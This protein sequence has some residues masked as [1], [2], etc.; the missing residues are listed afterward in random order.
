MI[1]IRRVMSM[2]IVS[3]MMIGIVP[4][5]AVQSTASTVQPVAK[6]AA[7]NDILLDA[8][9]YQV[10][11][12]GQTSN[13]A[14]ILP[15]TDQDV[16]YIDVVAQ[17]EIS[18]NMQ[19]S[20]DEVMLNGELS[21]F[22]PAGR[23]IASDDNSGNA[24]NP[25]I[26]PTLA[27]TT[28]R[29]AIW[30]RDHAGT[31]TGSYQLTATVSE[32]LV[33][34][35]EYSTFDLE[36]DP[37]PEAAVSIDLPELEPSPNQPQNASVKHTNQALP[38]TNYPL[39][40]EFARDREILA[41]FSPEAFSIEN[42]SQAFTT[43]ALV[44][45]DASQMLVFEY[46]VGRKTADSITPLHVEVL[47]GANFEA[48]T[49]IS[50]WRIKGQYR[51]GW[52]TGRLNIQ[53][54]RGQTIK[55]RFINDWW[56]IDQPSAQVRDLRLT[57]EIPDWELSN[58]G[59]F[60]I[61]NDHLIGA[62]AVITGAS[63]SLISAPINLNQQVQSLSFRYRT[64]RWQHDGSAPL[65]VEILSGASFARIT[66][67]DQWSLKGRLTDGW[68]EAVLDIQ[69]F[70]G[71]TIKIKI[72]NDWWPHH[73]QVTSIDRFTLNRAVPGWDISNARFVRTNTAAQPSGTP[74][75]VD[76]EQDFMAFDVIE[77]ADFEQTQLV[78]AEPQQPLINLE[79]LQTRAS[80][81]DFAVP[82]AATSIHFEYLLGDL[83]DPSATRRL[84]ITILSGEN[85]EILEF[86][87]GHSFVGSSQAGWQ[88]GRLDLVGYRGKT[89]KL[90]LINDA[91]GRP[92]SQ[93]RA[94]KLVQDVPAWQSQNHQALSIDQNPT[95]G[96]HGYL[97]GHA[98]QL[99]SLDF[100]VP[101]TAQQVRFD[102]QAGFSDNPAA[103]Q[104][105][106]ISILSGR[107]FEIIYPLPANSLLGSTDQ[108]W[109]AL[110]LDLQRFQDQ[111]IKLQF[112]LEAHN[113]AYLR[114]DNVQVGHVLTGWSSSEHTP[115][116]L[117]TSDSN[118]QV[119]RFAG[120]NAH[121]T[122]DAWTVLYDTEALQF[123]YKT[124]HPDAWLRSV[125]EVYVLSGAGFEIVTPIDAGSVYGH[126]NDPN[127]GWH[128]ARLGL[129]QFQGQTI[130]LQFRHQGHGDSTSWLD[131][132]QLI[133]GETRA[134]QAAYHAP[135]HAF[136][137]MSQTWQ[138]V[139]SSGFEV[140]NDSQF[141]RFVYQV[142]N[143]DHG[144]AQHHLAV[145]V[146][147][148]V[149]FTIITRIDQNQLYRSLNDGW[150]IAQL[151]I[152]QFQNQTIK[153]RFV[154]PGWVSAPIARIDKVALLS[155]R[156]SITGP[157]DVPGV[158]YLNV[159][160]AEL[161]GTTTPTTMTINSLVMYDDYMDVAGQVHYSNMTYPFALSG[162]LY[163]SS[164]GT[165]GDIVADLQDTT[166]TFEALYFAL[167]QHPFGPQANPSIVDQN[168]S[169]YLQ[170]HATREATLVDLGL[171]DSLSTLL[172]PL[173]ELSTLT[174]ARYADD[175]WFGK[176]LEPHST[177]EALG[178]PDEKKW[179]WKRTTIGKD[180]SLL[181]RLDFG[182]V[183]AV[184]DGNIGENSGKFGSQLEILGSISNGYV[185]PGQSW[186]A[187]SCD[188][189]DVDNA[190]VTLGSK[191]DPVTVKFVSSG[192]GLTGNEA[193]G[194]Y[195][196]DATFGGDATRFK[197]NQ[198]WFDQFI[199]DLIKSVDMAS[200]LFSI[201][202][203]VGDVAQ[204][205]PE[206]T[207]DMGDKPSLVNTMILNDWDDN[208]NTKIKVL[209]VPFQQSV[210]VKQRDYFM[211]S[212]TVACKK[213]HSNRDMLLRIYWEIPL[214]DN[215]SRKELNVNLYNRSFLV[216]YKSGPCK[217]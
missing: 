103:R 117:E 85:F 76:F 160:L 79:G 4:S 20:A 89:I 73:P 90:Q 10:L 130:K 200:K 107:N 9:D 2:L 171:D 63:A 55:L 99:T 61:H 145:E 93:I 98:M 25:Q 30:V 162:D 144:N 43:E 1:P 184:P 123:N 36:P 170:R 51:L 59:E 37:C 182:V 44:V 122:S 52:Q 139:T 129:A 168:L 153:I 142:G 39:N 41:T 115:F 6:H 66:N 111:K 14:T 50:N 83:D 204:L 97:H 190:G 157:I 206:S 167:R 78:L 208:P 165:P 87:Q 211:V 216:D 53:A 82:P 101:L 69:A 175:Y 46:M 205:F 178:D 191:D 7:L 108:G 131:N 146:L 198:L 32:P 159:P 128:E 65:F 35:T 203:T 17:Q 38:P 124:Q 169:L 58:F 88:Q 48:V 74:L 114:L 189:Y 42:A 18:V 106:A 156:A 179:T 180:C 112:T 13:V 188:I 3:S 100:T 172:S 70:R 49:N 104:R 31:R 132:L 126:G 121:F 34:A 116:V 119:V 164:L 60:A 80:S 210:L 150:K 154:A 67:I 33:A 163:H 166:G 201:P 192:N 147:S 155:P 28:G 125:I 21:L 151:P 24:G 54:F 195:L 186:P 215:V 187:D 194:D 134:K 16:F 94:L 91:Y 209:R 213:Q 26:G 29:Y 22:D 161:A 105:V 113:T 77:N 8:D 174:N 86:P 176:L 57:Q 71:Q 75:N 27:P 19:R 141:L 120:N 177:F 62:Y 45:P 173:F 72:I 133:A 197:G 110:A 207:P 109:Q 40:C 5:K 193:Q 56:W 102:Y 217:N 212:A 183:V 138:H 158:T 136:I 15:K 47:S 118:R 143:K 214:Y 135:D 137:E 23:L 140:A 127:N 148:G 84:L 92:I 95:Q 152:Q 181:Q 12:S 64:G 185:T 149:D 96:N 199:G 11:S 196:S 202:I 68:H 81:V